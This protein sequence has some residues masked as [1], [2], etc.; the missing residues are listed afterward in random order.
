MSRTSTLTHASQGIS[1]PALP[2]PVQLEPL[3]DERKHNGS[4]LDTPPLDEADPI[5]SDTSPETVSR[6]DSIE[7]HFRGT[8]HE[9]TFI[10][11]VIMAQLFS[12]MNLGNT[13]I[14]AASIADTFRIGEVQ[15]SWFVA[16]YSTTVGAFVLVTG[17]LGDIY[18][19]KTLWMIGWTWLAVFSLL[20]GFC[21]YVQ[22]AVLFD[23]FRALMGIGPATLMPNASALLG[24]AFPPGF[25]KNLAF[26]IFGAVAPGGYVLGLT[27]GAI[28]TQI[29]EDWRWTYWSM[30]FLCLTMTFAAWLV[31]PSELNVSHGGSFDW[32]GSLVGISGLVLIFFAFKYGAVYIPTLLVVGL[33][34]IVLFVLIENRTED[35]VMPMSMFTK[36]AFAAVIV[37]LACGWMS[38]GMF[39]Y[40]EPQF[41]MRLRGISMMELCL[42]LIPCAACGAFAAATA[43]YLLPRVPAWTVFLASMCFFCISQILLALTPV[44]QSYWPMTFPLTVLVSIGP[45]L[46]F[47]SASLIVSD[48]VSRK[49]QGAAG[50][51][52]N[53]VVNYS[54]GLGLAFGGNIEVSTNDHGRDT[55][56]GYRSA[57]WLGA[58]FAGLGVVLTILSRK[59]MQRH[60]QE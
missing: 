40:Y 9:I 54:I 23:V 51:F 29:A 21:G 28:F 48:Q 3:R 43:V 4:F 30:T 36:P 57:W 8:W 37:S 13:I 10:L 17:R 34:L 25:K 56:K 2:S 7:S 31:I 16:S 22:S 39:Q 55:L 50:S 33:L 44:N 5:P 18:G 49:Q 6:E 11:V 60:K 59:K 58:G 35:P 14:Q 1:Q 45:D 12:Q 20:C 32:L 26:A 27:W 47:A 24:T 38:F 41:L 19:I 52:I 42:Q 46:S 53:T 15:E